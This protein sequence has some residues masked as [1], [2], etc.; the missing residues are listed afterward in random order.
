MSRKVALSD[1]SEEER[2]KISA[3][4]EITPDPPKAAP[5]SK[6]KPIYLYDVDDEFVYLPFSYSQKFPRPEREE[7]PNTFSSSFQ[8]ELRPQQ[9]EVRKEAVN[10]LNKNGAVIIAAYPSFGKT[11]LAIN[12]A[13]KIK[14]KTLIICHRVVLINQWR[15]S[16]KKFTGKEPQILSPKTRI[17]SDCDFFIMN[18]IN[19]PK[20]TRDEWSIIGF[21]VCDELHILMAER[22]SQ[23]MR[24]LIP[25]YVL[26]LSA[27]P[28]R[29]D[30]LDILLDM[31]C[32]EHRIERKLYRKH[33]VYKIE[34]GF[35][36]EEKMNKLGKIDWSSIIDST[37]NNK[38]RNEIII[39]LVKKFK[40]RV[41]LILCKRVSQAEYIFDRLVEEGEDVTSLIGKNQEYE[42]KSRILVGTSGKVSVGF[43]NPNLNTLLLASDVEQ[44]FIQVLGRIFRKNDALEQP[45]ILDIVDDHP[46]LHKHF[47]TRTQ[48]YFEHG[49]IL[50]NFRKEFPEVNVRVEE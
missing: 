2:S 26:G 35:K 6:P 21:V 16:I 49:G 38:K 5:F 9:Q 31:Y 22:L 3:E 19:V 37:C 28:Y 20:K 10:Y 29:P 4:L 50:K 42:Q 25:R 12:I 14:L 40:K 45:M 36:P 8:G 23:S 39:E 27:T 13:C 48:V 44:Y 15:D 46:I 30:G 43:D 47:R 7:F 18:A 17:D 11:C 34:T 33:L 24:Y 1:L 41:F 32:G